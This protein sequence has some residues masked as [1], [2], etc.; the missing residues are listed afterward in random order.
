MDLEEMQVFFLVC[1]GKLSIEMGGMEN[2]FILL[3]YI[4]RKFINLS[5]G[6]GMF[7]V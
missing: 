4:L 1:K 5:L 3:L 2:L 7:L 6:D